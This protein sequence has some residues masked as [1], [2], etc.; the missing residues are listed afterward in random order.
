MSSV[1]AEGLLRLAKNN[2][3]PFGAYAELAEDTRLCGTV[4]RGP[5]LRRLRSADRTERMVRLTRCR[6]M[7][8]W[9]ASS[10]PSGRGRRRNP[11]PGSN[12]G[13]Q[14]RGG[15][16]S[17]TQWRLVAGANSKSMRCRKNAAATTVSIGAG[18]FPASASASFP[19]MRASHSL[20]C[21]E[22]TLDSD[23]A[24]KHH[25]LTLHLDSLWRTADQRQRPRDFGASR[26]NLTT[27]VAYDGIAPP[28]FRHDP[29]TGTSSVTYHTD[30]ARSGGAS[31]SDAAENHKLRVRTVPDACSEENALNQSPATV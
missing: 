16:I 31:E 29:R 10:A 27:T 6:S 30:A 9:G 7:T 17:R 28:D 20:Q 21:D 18:A 24:A 5:F 25:H 4:A 1:R 14:R 19:K 15:I 13:F 23:R 2:D 3:R 22:Q 11:D 26:S 12:T 8:P